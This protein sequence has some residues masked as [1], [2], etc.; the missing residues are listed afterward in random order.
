MYH[1]TISVITG[2][3]R[4]RHHAKRGRNRL[5]LQQLKRSSPTETSFSMALWN[6][7][8]A[9]NKT[10]FIAGYANHLSLEL[11]ALTETGIK[12]EN[13][14]TPAALSTNLTLSHTPRPSGRGG[15]TGL[16]I[17]NKWKFTP[18]LPSNKY[19]SF[20]FHAITVIAPAK[21]YVLVIYRPPGQLGD[22]LDELDTL[23]SSI[24][25]HDCPL[26]LLGDINIHLDAPGSADFLA[27][28]HSFDLKL[29]QSP[30]THKAGKEL[31]LI[32]TRNC[33]TDTL[34]V[35]PLHL[36]DHFFIQ[37][38][39]SLTEQPPAPQPM[40]TFRRN[41]RNLSPTHFSSVV[42]SGLPPLNTFS[43]LEVNEATDSLCSTLSSCLDELCPLTTRPARSKHSHPW[44]ND[45]LRS[46]RTRLRAAERKWHKSKLTDDLKNY[47]TLL[48]SFSASITAAKTAF[49]NDKINSATDTRKLFSTFK[50]LLNPQMPPPPSSLTA[51]TLA[52]FFTNKVAAISSQFSTCPLN[53][54]D[55]DTALLQPLG[56]ARSSFSAF[57]PLSE[58]EVSRLLTCS[59]PTT[60][61]L[62]PIP[63]SLLQSISPTIAPAITHVINASLTSGTFPTAFKMARVTPLLKKAS[64]NPAQVE[65]YR[66]VSLLP[67]LSKGIERAVSKQVSD[68]LSQNNLLDPNQSG[69]KSGHSTETALLSV[70]KA[71]KEARATARSSVLI[72]LD[73]SA[74][75]DTVNHRILLSILANMGISGSA[76]SWFESYLTGRS[77]NV[78]WLGQLSA[79]H[80]LTT[81]VPQGSVLGPL[82]FAIYTTSLGQI[83]RSHGFSYHC[84]ADDTQ[85]YLSFPPDDPSVSARISDCLSDI[86]TWMKAHHLQLNLSKTEL[87][88]LPAKP[89][90]HHDINIK[91][92]SLSV[93]PTRT[94]RNLGVVLDNQ[95]NF[96]DHVASVARSCRF[97]LYNIRK[98]RTYLNQ[99]ATQLLVQ[100]IVISRLDYCNALLTGLPACAVKPLQ[101]IQNAAARLVYNQ[102]KRAHVT[103]LLIQLHW[104]PMAARIKFKALTLAYKVVSGSAP[105]YLNAF[106][107]TYAT[108]RP[109]RSSDER[110]LALPPVR[111]GQSKLFS[112]V[113]PRWWNTLPVPTRAGTSLSIFKKL[114]KTQL[115][116][117]HL[118]S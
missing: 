90:I 19:V 44:L 6:C 39:V 101:M 63:T 57:T 10:D 96:S 23:L 42:A 104:L 88:V 67:F 98:I 56:T 35:T 12:P 78:S 72:L 59:R 77:F 3:R 81:G 1:Y 107:Q 87:L 65:N 51:D 74:A 27:L 33:S 83:I 79:P 82:L 105:T 48:A 46:Q 108:S 21:L 17:S 38:N 73:L 53:A 45:T 118:L 62:D 34:T 58:N 112:S 111:S 99:D 47:Q 70:T 109:L 14:A 97:A 66:P 37:F 80:H 9:V 49:Y 30:P 40:V 60:C 28:I 20:E 8:S 7:Q 76:L 4:K 93:S 52:S 103:P 100:A 94:A 24:P 16:L 41:I 13:T 106:I 64:L 91:F 26:L 11:L 113:V 69:F 22:F 36:S 116:R 110:R 89:T 29:V 50:S 32:F 55:S 5:N 43:S 54:S 2:H 114:L 61:S 68:F 86:A 71:L 31:D 115:F 25:E 117:E 85:L 84:Y 75:F 18:L 15:G 92:D 102:P 95:L